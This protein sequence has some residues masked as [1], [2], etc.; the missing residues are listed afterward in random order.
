MIKTHKV[1]LVDLIALLQD[2]GLKDTQFMVCTNPRALKWI[3]IPVGKSEN[4]PHFRLH[5]SELERELTRLSDINNQTADALW[6]L[7]PRAST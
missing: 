7:E 2:A 5:F 6:R 3:L 4:I 1:C